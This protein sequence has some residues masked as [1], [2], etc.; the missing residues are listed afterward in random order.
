MANSK[1]S[2]F[3]IYNVLN[4]G[5]RTLVLCCLLSS[6]MSLR[7]WS[8]G[9]PFSG[10]VKFNR[11]GFGAGLGVALLLQA[12]P[13]FAATVT[14][15]D[16]KK[17]VQ[18]A[19]AALVP[20]PGLLQA[21]KWDAVRTILKIDLGKLWALGESQNPI[22]QFARSGDEPELFEL[23][24]ELSTALQSADQFT[25]TN[26]FIYE[27]PGAGKLNTKDPIKQI[28]LAKSKLG[29]IQAVLDGL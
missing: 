14:L 20:V 9:T 10:L 21:E 8:Q 25:Y 26:I 17:V 23:L 19:S 6:S 28:T 24:E 16:A 1:R 12:R 13:V 5:M 3:L 22:V 4:A 27:Q 2:V 18:D 7:E 15:T 29:E 11:R